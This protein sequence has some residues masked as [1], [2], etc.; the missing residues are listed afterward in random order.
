MGF[1]EEAW[2][3]SEL[4]SS[5]EPSYL[6]KIRRATHLHQLNPRM[7]SG[8]LQG[9]ILSM[10]AKMLCPSQI[11]EVGT[12]TGYSALCLAEG[13]SPKGRLVTVEAN[14]ELRDTILS[15]FKSSPFTG[16]ITLEMGQALDIIPRLSAVFDLVFIDADKMN[17]PAYYDLALTKTT[18]GGVIILD[19]TLWDGKVFD[20]HSCDATTRM[21][22]AFNEQVIKDPSVET[23]MLPV[24]DGLTILRKC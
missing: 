9:R 19:N 21:F 7:C 15:N 11:L 5:P 6:S 12:F 23:L 2:E 18:Q 8:H 20:S 24:R 10:M 1:F 13:L 4:H 16:N 22:Q 3:Y 14:E 17:Y